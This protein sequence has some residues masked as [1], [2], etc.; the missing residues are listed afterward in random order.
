MLRQGPAR[1][2]PV[3]VKGFTGQVFVFSL[4]KSIPRV[5]G[6]VCPGGVR[7]NHVNV[8]AAW[9]KRAGSRPAADFYLTTAGLTFRSEQS[10]IEMGAVVAVLPEAHDWVS[11]AILQ[12][13]ARQDVYLFHARKIGDRF[14]P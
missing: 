11:S 7:V 5:V 8:K 14:P 12:L 3:R 9:P 1:P 2:P 13:L 6:E 10:A 4:N